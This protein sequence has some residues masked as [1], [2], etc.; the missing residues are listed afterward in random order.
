MGVGC[1]S[2]GC[3]R[4]GSAGGRGCGGAVGDAW[5]HAAEG[6]VRA[7]GLFAE[8]LEVVGCGEFC[9]GSGKA[10]TALLWGLN[11]GA[12]QVPVRAGV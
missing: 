3:D 10:G 9:S 1:V 7:A 6:E 5:V 12:F 8:F 4:A 2:G 11:A